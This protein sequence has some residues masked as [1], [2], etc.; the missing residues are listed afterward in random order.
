M[1]EVWK[2][3]DAQRVARKACRQLVPFPVA[4][5]RP[6]PLSLVDTGRGPHPSTGNVCGCALAI[7]T[8]AT[9]TEARS[10]EGASSN[11]EARRKSDFPRGSSAERERG[12]AWGG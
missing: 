11:A 1:R 2:R 12:L 7:A 6:L 8:Q 10:D 3:N 5:S 4:G 9:A